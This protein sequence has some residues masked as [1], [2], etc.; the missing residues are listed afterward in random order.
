[1]TEF[2]E[3][4][5]LIFPDITETI[6]DLEKRYPERNL[7]E[8]AIVARFAPSPTGFLHT[9]S[10][11]ATLIAWKFPRQTNGVF[12]TRLED[13]DTK[14]EIE[15]SGVELLKQLEAFGIIPNEGYMGTYEKGQYGPYKQSNRA[16][17]YK[18][19]IKDFIKRGLAYP[20][21]CSSEDLTMLRAYQE[22]NKLNP[23]YYGEYA[24]CSTLSPKVAMEKIQNGEPYVIRFR[25]QGNYQNKVKIT[26]LI[27]GNLELAQN[28][29][30]IVI[31]KSDGLPTYH[32]AHLVDDHFMRT[33]HVTRGEEWLPSLPIHY[34]LFDAAGWK[35][36]NY[37]HLPVIMKLDNGNR[38]KLSKRKDPEASVSYFL[39]NGYPVE[40]I[41]E[42]LVTIAN[43][44]FE[45]WRLQNMSAD[46][47]TF[48]LSFDKMTLDGA[49]FDLAKVEN[50]CKER[51]SRLNKEEFTN[52]AYAFA[53][54]YD[55]QLKNLIER[56]PEFFKSI[57]NIEREKENPRK[58]YTTY[59]DIYP[60]ISFFYNDLY[61]ALL[62]TTELP[63][64]Y[65]RFTKDTI[66]YVLETFK[67]NMGLE[68]DE[69]GWFNNLKETTS[70]CGFCPN[71]KE[72][73]K[74]KEAYPGHVGDISEMIR[75]AFSTRKNTPNPY[76]VLQILG[77]K[78][79]ARRIDKVIQQLK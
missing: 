64:N 5:E 30:H 6:T 23:G 4:A 70:K 16:Q 41:L 21:F 74:N 3:L 78:E 45:E 24:K 49:L 60:I 77:E 46:I 26:D 73:K 36:P 25:S 20:C 28:D 33:T 63:F 13:T 51:L 15:G 55:E 1:M 53:I 2:E 39:E 59:K 68:Y 69:E 37:A 35:R 56:N 52:K 29:Q 79:V 8:G 66:I 50:I 65:E 38:R 22:K 58:D 11:F 14:R 9:G 27:R 7:P 43:S 17:I 71:V 19:V 62:D 34:E 12:Y 10:L 72:Y 47:F 48:P 61:D 31:L 42:Y 75:I 54:E 18:I 40:G 67:S 32:F 44:N 76:F 57:I